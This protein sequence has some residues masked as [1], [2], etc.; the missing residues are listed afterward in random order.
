MTVTNSH[1]SDDDKV[2]DLINQMDSF[3]ENY[4]HLQ[5]F[6]S[7]DG[8]PHCFHDN[9]FLMI[10][11]R[12]FG[13][14]K[15][16]DLNVEGDYINIEFFDCCTQQIG[17]VRIDIHDASPRTFFI[18]WQDIKNMVLDDVTTKYSNDELLDF[19]F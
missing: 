11:P 15:V 7:R 10:T 1:I 4:G 9:E 13:K 19:D 6:L 8:M 18:C 12:T 2:Q 16:L 14:V 17:N 5:I 3:P